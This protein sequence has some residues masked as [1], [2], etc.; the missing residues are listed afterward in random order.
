MSVEKII[1]R[2]PP[3]D[4][5][6]WDCQC[7]RC[8]S[9]MVYEECGSCDEN[10]M[11]HHDCGEDSCCCADPEPNVPCDLCNGEGGWLECASDSGWCMSNPQEGRESVKRGAIEWFTFDKPRVTKSKVPS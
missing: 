7:A 3:R 4:G 2:H 6:E 1:A 10:G 11:S 9:S 5:R 8:G